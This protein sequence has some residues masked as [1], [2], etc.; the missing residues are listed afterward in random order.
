MT[1]LQRDIQKPNGMQPTSPGEIITTMY[2]EPLSISKESF[3][4]AMGIT[5]A[6]ATQ[7]LQ[8][9]IPIDMDLSLRLSTVFSTSYQLWLNLQS[10]YDHKLLYPNFIH[11]I[12]PTLTKLTHGKT[13]Q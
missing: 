13:S 5:E 9:E 12:K 4:H 3:T 11:L 2:L 7:L 1:A 6:A 8:G 10:N